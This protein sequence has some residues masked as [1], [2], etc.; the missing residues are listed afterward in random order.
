VVTEHHWLTEKQFV[1]IAGAVV[2]IARRSIVDLPTALIAAATIVL[3]WRYR[4]LQ[5]PVVIAAAAIL[6]VLIYRTIDQL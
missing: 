6:G 1:A 5:E 4:K 3:L 2:V